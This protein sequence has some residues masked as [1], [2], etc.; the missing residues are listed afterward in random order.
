MCFKA[1]LHRHTRPEAAPNPTNQIISQAALGDS[2]EFYPT[3]RNLPDS[4]SP[5][6]LAATAATER[7]LTESPA[8]AKTSSPLRRA[9]LLLSQELLH[10]AP[11]LFPPAL[12]TAP[13]SLPRRR[14]HSVGGSTMS[15]VV[16]ETGGR[17]QHGDVCGAGDAET[18]YRDGTSASMPPTSSIARTRVD[19]DSRTLRILA[20]S[21]AMTAVAGGTVEKEAAVTLGSDAIANIRA[22]EEGEHGDGQS[23]ERLATSAIEMQKRQHAWLLEA[24]DG[25]PTTA[26]KKDKSLCRRRWQRSRHPGG[27]GCVPGGYAGYLSVPH[28]RRRRSCKSRVSIKVQQPSTMTNTLPTLS[29]IADLALTSDA[30]GL[31]YRNHQA[32]APRCDVANSSAD[33]GCVAQNPRPGHQHD[34]SMLL[35]PTRPP[36]ARHNKVIVS[37][38]TTGSDR[39]QSGGS[40][41]ASTGTIDGR[42]HDHMVVVGGA[43]ARRWSACSIFTSDT[44]ARR[45]GCGEIIRAE[46]DGG[47]GD[48]RREGW[49]QSVTPRSS[50]LPPAVAALGETN[51]MSTKPC[52]GEKRAALITAPH[53]KMTSAAP[54]GIGTGPRT[55]AG[56]DDATGADATDAVP[57]VTNA[58]GISTIGSSGIICLADWEGGKVEDTT[59][60]ER[61]Y[62]TPEA[63]KTNTKC[64][65]DT[66]VGFYSHLWAHTSPNVLLSPSS[67]ASSRSSRSSPRAS[68]EAD[69]LSNSV[70]EGSTKSTITVAFKMSALHGDDG[71]GGGDVGAA[72]SM[73]SPSTD[74]VVDGNAE[75]GT[76]SADKVA[77]FA[78][79]WAPPPASIGVAFTGPGECGDDHIFVT[80]AAR[81][82]IGCTV[83]TEHGRKEG[84]D[85]RQPQEDETTR[86]ATATSQKNPVEPTTQ[87]VCM[88]PSFF[89]HLWCEPPTP[90]IAYTP[91]AGKCKHATVHPASVG[92]KGNEVQGAGKETP[93][94]QSDPCDTRDWSGSISH[95]MP[96]PTTPPQEVPGRLSGNRGQRA[97]VAAAASVASPE[98]NGSDIFRQT[99]REHGKNTMS[100]SFY[101]HLYVDGSRRHPETAGDVEKA[102]PATPPSAVRTAEGGK[103]FFSHLWATD[104][105]TMSS[106]TNLLAVSAAA[107]NGGS[108]HHC[109]ERRRS[110]T[111]LSPRQHKSGQE[112]QSDRRHPLPNYPLVVG[113]ASVS[114]H[115][116]TPRF[117]KHCAPSTPSRLPLTLMVA[118][119]LSEQ[120]SQPSPW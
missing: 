21:A 44:S 74:H 57:A 13:E 67:S 30:A 61:E 83:S 43:L 87:E 102:S 16:P 86:K 41:Q 105:L 47:S 58:T 18:Q 19:K 53:D 25:C 1:P 26:T 35:I 116:A 88:G 69:I 91:P 66:K 4:T 110:S 37:K 6:T 81:G 38:T 111:P 27:P 32:S 49:T 73:A 46:S 48:R 5:A 85:C 15:V 78:H 2:Y 77:F 62:Q 108:D 103:C 96:E 106:A 17:S 82:A 10:P 100:S 3:E 101:P 7:N 24:V 34:Q 99:C 114:H 71:H 39:V 54:P 50:A 55:A 42:L 59:A 92:A 20:E 36:H 89:S 23:S 118:L 95:I 98:S 33:V 11:T 90:H 72:K 115:K 109:D 84:Q 56:A 68:P 51:L 8:K 64:D 79:L 113:G 52:R 31:N 14:T 45:D 40:V 117:V 94:L 22:S 65:I 97:R 29:V 9:H 75:D 70:P 76:P 104:N 12:A 120:L 28:V 63:G 60:Q 112:E 119:V 80:P 93:Q 107:G